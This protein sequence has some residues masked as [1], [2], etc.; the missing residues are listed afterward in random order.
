MNEQN[1]TSK[2]LLDVIIDAIQ[3][4]KGRR[5]AILNMDGID[6]AICDY[7]VV[8]EGN[9][10]TQVEAILDSISIKTKEELQERPHH[11]HVGSGEWIAMDYLD[12]I[13]HIFVPALRSYYNIEQL[14]A[15]A[16]L[17]QVPDVD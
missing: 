16:Q 13:V 15:D 3:D 12:I 4:K 2:E 9:T 7:M 14:W 5:I 10:P 6:E 8:A 11:V 1:T 17:H